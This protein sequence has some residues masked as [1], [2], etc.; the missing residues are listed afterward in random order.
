MQVYFCLVTTTQMV[1]IHE[2]EVLFMSSQCS[3]ISGNVLATTIG[4]NNNNNN[5]LWTY[6]MYRE[7]IKSLNFHYPLI[8]IFDISRLILLPIWLFEL[9]F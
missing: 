8:F 6:G 3:F 9:K 5:I 4:S 1:I 7:D 2:I